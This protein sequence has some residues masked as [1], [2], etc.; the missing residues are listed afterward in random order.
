MTGW[1]LF[2]GELNEIFHGT[3]RCHGPFPGYLVVLSTLPDPAVPDLDDITIHP[4]PRSHLIQ[5][6]KRPI[7]KVER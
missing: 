7:E 6:R 4:A 1:R 5:V 3:F 2:P